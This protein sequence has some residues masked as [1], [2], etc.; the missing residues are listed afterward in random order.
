MLPSEEDSYKLIREKIK[1][2]PV[3]KKKLLKRSL[4]TAILAIIFG[5]I[6]CIT[7]FLMEPVLSNWLYPDKEAEQ[8]HFPEDSVETLPED[9]IQTEAEAMEEAFLAEYD[10]PLSV[11]DE[12]ATYIP[13]SGI[14]VTT[15][16]DLTNDQ[17]VQN[18]EINDVPEITPEISEDPA[19]TLPAEGSDTQV[20]EV[21]PEDFSF[22]L[23]DFSDLYKD[24][25]SVAEAAAPYLVSIS[26]YDDDSDIF[27]FLTAKKIQY[28]GIIV[29]DNGV[30]LL[31]MSKLS[32]SDRA[33]KLYATFCDGFEVSAT[34]RDTDPE[35]GIS[36][37]CVDLATIDDSTKE[38]YGFAALGSSLSGISPGLPV[39]AVGFPLGV[40]GSVVFG[41]VTSYGS[42]IQKQ[43]ANYRLITTDIYASKNSNGVLLNLNGQ[44]IGFLDNSYNEQ[45]MPN[46]L[47]A[48]G[49]TELKRLIEQLSNEN[50]R[51]YLGIY[52]SDITSQLS[53]NLNLPR[54]VYVNSFEIDS[55]AM[56]AGIQA[57]DII[58]EIN[59]TSI[60]SMKELTSYLSKLLPGDTIVLHIE[61][62]VQQN[63]KP[64][65]LTVTLEAF[66]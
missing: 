35:T 37:I 45:T 59:D 9:M 23:D 58:T 50:E 62:R 21:I 11:P 55:P 53:Q 7:F 15:P 46:Q 47:S 16:G 8:V 40:P 5:L 36:I 41:V 42:L 29:A 51:A 1:D 52:G 39:V 57:S 65:D 26:C 63:F 20:P 28:S 19:A 54:G 66:R 24:L 34:I 43:D 44:V 56:L 17:A 14:T 12:L 33:K 27:S 30:S 10:A 25:T 60:H 32:L 18:A 61:R 13:E 48:I 38:K 2:R 49:I 4:I 6:A 22:T 31:I 64:I 3:N